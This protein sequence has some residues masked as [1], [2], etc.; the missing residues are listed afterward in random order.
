VPILLSGVAA[1]LLLLVPFLD[2]GVVRR[3]RSPVFTLVGWLA[4]VYIVVL[5]AWGYDSLVPVYIAAGTGGL[6]LL[7]TRGRRPRRSGE[8]P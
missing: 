1:L 5:T 4:V 7:F 3:G 2:R 6:V 8:A